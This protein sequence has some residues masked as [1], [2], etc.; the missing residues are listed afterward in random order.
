MSISVKK[1][2]NQSVFFLSGD[3]TAELGRELNSAVFRI[4]ADLESIV[5]DFTNV[6]Y[7]NSS[8]ISML[9]ELYK[10]TR[11]HAL[12]IVVRSLPVEVKE[13]F[14]HARLNELFIIE[15]VSNTN[16]IEEYIDLFQSADNRD[17]AIEALVKMEDSIL[18]QLHQALLSENELIRAGA[19][20]TL[21]HLDDSASVG[22]ISHLLL[23]DDS[24]DVRQSAAFSL[25]LL[26]DEQAVPALAQSLKDSISEVAETAGRSLGI[27]GSEPAIQALCQALHDDS[28]RVRGVAAHSL[29]MISHHAALGDIERLTQDSDSWVRTCSIQALG[30]MRA[31]HSAPVIIQALRDPNMMVREAAAA[32]LGRIKAPDSVEPLS[33]GLSDE[34]MWVAFFAA[35]ALG[36]IGSPAAIPFLIQT[37]TTTEYEN[38]RIAALWALR[39]LKAVE[40]ESYF[41]EAF[42]E[43][44]EDIRKEALWGMAS[45]NH[46]QTVEFVLRALTDVRWI[47][48]YAALQIVAQLKLYML[49][50]DLRILLAEEKEDIVRC[51][52]SRV[53]VEIA[54]SEP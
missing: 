5:L 2:E 21:G 15:G 9:I 31:Q 39:E 24:S 8:G 28:P 48:R 46:P 50:P 20:V 34:N 52:I 14:M 3:F 41:I 11:Q 29:G 37:F 43:P 33:Q 45:I 7:I 12:K 30:W 44:N 47:V 18:P 17:E 53:L 27:I 26:M 38:V 25:G 32:S 40:A 10:K 36:Q 54:R 19:I 42:E 16:T 6:H 4:D 49:E 23:N 22:T 13:F 35:K 1:L 51:E